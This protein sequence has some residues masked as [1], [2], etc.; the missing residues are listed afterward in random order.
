MCQHHIIEVI[1]SKCGEGYST[2]EC[3]YRLEC[4]Y[5]REIS[6]T[7]CKYNMLIM[8]VLV[9]LGPWSNL[10]PTMSEYQNTITGNFAC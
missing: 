3:D 2:D 9:W 5:F 10:Q 4:V 6:L 8:I 1:M 7:D